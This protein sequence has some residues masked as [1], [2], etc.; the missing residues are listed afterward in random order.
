MSGVD[1]PRELL[2]RT[3]AQMQQALAQLASQLRPFPPFL[4]M[5]S[6]Q[7][8]EL[9]P[10]PELAARRDLGCIVA[11]PDGEICELELTAIA[12]PAGP[13]DVDQVERYRPLDLPP[14]DYLPL[15]AAALAAIYRELARRG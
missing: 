11:L 5:T 6:L 1:S 14:E 10:P 13:A 9:E 3:A 8:I 12:G 4:G 2:E 15:A 7:A